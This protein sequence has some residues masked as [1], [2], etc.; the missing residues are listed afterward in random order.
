MGQ[1]YRAVVCNK[2]GRNSYVFSSDGGLKLME[3]N[4]YFGCAILETVM[5]WLLGAQRRVAWVGDYASDCEYTNKVKRESWYKKAGWGIGNRS[6]SCK[7]GIACIDIHDV[8]YTDESFTKGYLVNHTKHEFVDLRDYCSR[9]GEDNYG[10]RIHPL[11]LLTVIGNGLGGGDYRGCNQH[12]VGRWAGDV[13]SYVLEKP[14]TSRYGIVN[15]RYDA[16]E[17]YSE[18][19]P[20]FD[21]GR[22]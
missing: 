14:N 3:S 4:A 8:D 10:W 5:V 22:N 15:G 2:N 20:V 6:G 13:I 1:Y 21:E 19:K 16:L 7:D 17:Y 12:D 18:I 9:V 11:P